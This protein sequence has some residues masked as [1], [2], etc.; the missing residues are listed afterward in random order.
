MTTTR[1]PEPGTDLLAGDM[2]V[3]WLRRGVDQPHYVDWVWA[4]REATQDLRD[5]VRREARTISAGRHPGCNVSAD[6]VM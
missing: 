5:K 4:A 6:E 1:F 2:A 3:Y